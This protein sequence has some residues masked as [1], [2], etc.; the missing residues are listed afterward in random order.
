MKTLTL[1]LNIIVCII[2]NMY[3]RENKKLCAM[4]KSRSKK[5]FAFFYL[6]FYFLSFLIKMCYI[7]NQEEKRKT[8]PQSKDYDR[9]NSQTQESP[10]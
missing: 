4:I 8:H 6:N 9:P 5:N 2:S 3:T 1:F 10:C 7:Q